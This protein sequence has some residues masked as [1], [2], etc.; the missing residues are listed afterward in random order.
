MLYVVFLKDK[1]V[2][3]ISVSGLMIVCFKVFRGHAQ[4]LKQHESISPT[5]FETLIDLQ[6]PITLLLHSL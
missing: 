3:N 5:Y 2:Y 6:G 1:D 4:L